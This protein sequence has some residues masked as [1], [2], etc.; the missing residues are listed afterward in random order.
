[1][2]SDRNVLCVL[3]RR[4]QAEVG[5]LEA[6]YSREA[7]AEERRMLRAEVAAAHKEK[8]RQEAAAAAASAPLRVRDAGPIL[9][10]PL[11]AALVCGGMP[12]TCVRQAHSCRGLA[13]GALEV[14]E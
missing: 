12:A 11:F 1:M 10:T 4:L 3:R 8:Q 14:L 6:K 7:V 13:L 5:E 9:S 2:R